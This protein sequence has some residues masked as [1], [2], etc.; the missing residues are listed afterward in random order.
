MKIKSFAPGKIILFGEHSVVHKRPAIAAAINRGV[1]VELTP[2]NDNIVHVVV[3]VIDYDKEHELTNF[4]LNYIIDSHNKMITD[5]IYEVINLFEF[6]NGFDINVDINMYLGVGLGSS[7]AVTVSTLKAVS[8]Y[9][10]EDYTKDQIAAIARSVE[11]KIQG[12]ASPIDTSMSTYGGIIYIDENFK[13]HP[14]D[15][16]MNLPLIVQNC[17]ISGN[18]G[19]LVESVRQKYEKYPKIVGKIFDAME[20]IAVDAKKALEEGNEE[21][22]SSYMNLNQ[23]L[24]DS[25]G[26]NTL[27]LSQM[28]YNIRHH[29]AKGSKLTGSGGGGCIIAFC[30]DNIDEVYD[31]IDNSYPKFKCEL[32]TDGVKAS[33]IN[34]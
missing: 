24:L 22:I 17:Q 2:R 34:D 14:V 9:A 32:S 10:N 4:Q 1:N 11:I 7:A 20:Q 31:C 12:A 26:V 21:H 3:P 27:E 30:P 19:K 29:G 5:Y 33:I 18:T 8:L 16:K 28:V 25:I 13:L 23:G 15:V 6:Q